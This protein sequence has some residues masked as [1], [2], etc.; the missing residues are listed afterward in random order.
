MFLDRFLTVCALSATLALGGCFAGED[1]L[2]SSDTPP[3]T[4]EPPPT[5][6][7]PTTPP[8]M[9]DTTVAS[10]KGR[11]RFLG[12]QAYGKRLSAGLSLEAGDLCS[13]LGRIDCVE[14]A[15][16][17]VLGGVDAER[18]GF[19]EPLPDTTVTTPFAVD[20]IA[21]TA[22]SRAA[23]RDLNA[24][25]SAAIFALVA[26]EQ[27]GLNSDDPA[28]A[29]SVR[30]LF[31]RLLQRVPTEAETEAVVDLYAS[32][33]NTNTETAARDWATAS[34]FAVATMAEALFY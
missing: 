29:A 32:I 1:T 17:I 31:I 24:P 30:E 5:T 2:S 27:G 25:E 13:E 3:P 34:C 19:L 16:N 10:T 18:L 4:T 9:G 7:P 11:V 33:Q 15:H 6:P 14:E 20:R 21:L 23:T 26:N 8:P 22:C 28:L 12:G